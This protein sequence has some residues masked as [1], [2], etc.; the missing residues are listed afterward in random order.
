MITLHYAEGKNLGKDIVKLNLKNRKELKSFLKG[1]QAKD[2][3][4]TVYLFTSNHSFD[5]EDE[6]NEYS[7]EIYIE[8]DPLTLRMLIENN[9]DYEDCVLYLQ[10]YA[11]FEDAYKVALD[12]RELN[13][14]CYN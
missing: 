1:I 10:E 2:N 12:M 5:P 3:S 7:R 11:S 9:L 4:D 14:L 13:N 8:S 6:F